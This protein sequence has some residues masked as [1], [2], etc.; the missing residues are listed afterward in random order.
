MERIQRSTITAGAGSAALAGAF[1]A[2]L[3]GG[4]LAAAQRRVPDSAA[5]AAI[6]ESCIKLYYRRGAGNLARLDH[7][8]AVAHAL[9]CASDLLAP[10]GGGGSALRCGGLLRGRTQQA[11]HR[12]DQV[13]DFVRAL[14][15]DNV[16]ARIRFVQT[17]RV[18]ELRDQDL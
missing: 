8:S 9:A 14:L 6:R 3:R 10:R 7:G 18:G 4:T 5:N 13:A 1:L 15:Y 11:V 16:R 2:G 17:K 12:A